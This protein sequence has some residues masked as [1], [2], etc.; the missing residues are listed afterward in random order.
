MG[1]KKKRG[2]KPYRDI[3]LNIMPFIDVFSVLT[4]FLLMVAVFVSVGIHEVQV[5]FLSSAPTPEQDKNTE[6][7]M[8]VK[9]E[10]EKDKLVLISSWDKGGKREQT[11]NFNT[12][13]VGLK[14]FH[15]ALIEL[16]N[17]DPKNELVTMFI[18]EDVKFEAISKVLDEVKILQDG[19]KVE[20]SEEKIAAA[21]T[22]YRRLRLA[23]RSLF[24]KVVFGSVAL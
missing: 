18:E 8:S 13:D 1:K 4:T 21:G 16:K 3:E 24:P 14:E 2:S 19:E 5:P 15:L 9:I 23:R 11:Q 7:S 6:P 20:V 10:V 12:D 22:N 17:D